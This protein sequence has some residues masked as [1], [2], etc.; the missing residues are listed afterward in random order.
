MANVTIYSTPFCV[1]CKMSK[2][3]F[4]KHNVA[5]EEKDV[6]VDLA[7]REDMI[8]KSGQMGVPVIDVDGTIVVGF[9]QGRLKQLLHLD[10]VA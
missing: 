6:A 4:Q 10:A 3:F 7:A 5:Y 1:Y 2:D 9:D 8:R